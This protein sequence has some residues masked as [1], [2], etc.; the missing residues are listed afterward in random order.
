MAAILSRL[1]SAGTRRWRVTATSMIG[2]I[3]G[4]GIVVQLDRSWWILDGDGRSRGFLEQAVVDA[5][6]RFPPAGLATAAAMIVGAWVILF[7][8]IFQPGD[9][10]D[11]RRG[12]VAPALAH[13]RAGPLLL[14]EAPR[15]HRSGAHGSADGG[16][17][18]EPRRRMADRRFVSRSS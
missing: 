14:G 9:L 1:V 3:A 15:A 18:V 12:G 2:F 5:A 16:D 7:D 6:R 8:P 13:G 17:L 4:A 10:A 11:G